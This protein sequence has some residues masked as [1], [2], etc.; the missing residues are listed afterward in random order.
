[1][2]AFEHRGDVVYV[3]A[4]RTI[5]DGWNVNATVVGL[6]GVRFSSAQE[7]RAAGT[8]VARAYLDGRGC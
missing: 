2:N 5:V 3:S 6:A 4:Y 1:M 8:R 7:A